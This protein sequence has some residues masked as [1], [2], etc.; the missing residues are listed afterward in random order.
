MLLYVKPLIERN[1][2]VISYKQQN[3]HLDFRSHFQ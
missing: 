2:T 3:V 1:V